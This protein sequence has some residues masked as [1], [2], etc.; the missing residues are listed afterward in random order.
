MVWINL[1]LG[2]RSVERALLGLTEVNAIYLVNIPVLGDY[3]LNPSHKALNKLLNEKKKNPSY[4]PLKGQRQ[5]Q[6][7]DIFSYLTDVYQDT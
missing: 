4:T 6:A 2:C 1:H 3:Y 7:L 5:F